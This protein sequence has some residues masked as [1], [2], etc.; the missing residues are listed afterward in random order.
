MDRTK[1]MSV[2]QKVFKNYAMLFIFAVL[3]AVFS[4]ANPSFC[5]WLNIKNLII[6]NTYIVVTAVGISFVMMS[7]ALDLS[8]GYQVAAIGVLTARL[9]ML[10]NLPVLPSVIIAIL[11]GLF[12]GL[13]N[14]GLAVLF[15]IEPLIV[16]IATMTIFRGMA[17]IISKGL[18]YNNFPDSFRTITRGTILGIP[19]DVYIAILAVALASVIFNFT[20]Y[21]R[22]VKAMGGNEEATRLA[23]VN[24]A[25]MRISTFAISGIFVAIAS[26]IYISK[27]STSNATYGPGIE[28]TGMTA[29]ILGGISFNSGEGKMWGLVVGI[30]TLAIIENGM[31]LG[32]LN[33]YIQ[34]IVKGSILI[35]AI[36]FDKYQRNTS[37]RK[38]TT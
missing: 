33:Q 17:N 8:V 21:G 29:A 22:F 34:Y 20:Y 24:I 14:G 19:I 3:F 15:K 30:F 37:V 18:A 26:F 25:L 6:Q 32:G 9:M 10:E 27:L 11:F 1:I 35:L 36:A 31:Q 23:G 13:I 16:T 28:F 2:I 38:K 4:I 7:G 12:L 5:S